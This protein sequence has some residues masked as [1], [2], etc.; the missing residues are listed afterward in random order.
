MTRRGY[1][2]GVQWIADNDEPDDLIFENVI[3]YISTMLLADLFCKDT[4]EVAADI[5]R[6]RQA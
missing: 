5:I 2:F 3:A 1:R 4:D 6:R